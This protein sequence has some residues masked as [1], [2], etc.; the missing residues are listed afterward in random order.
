MH[1]KQWPEFSV[2]F[3]SSLLA[4]GESQQ[5]NIDNAAGALKW[6]CEHSIGIGR[7]YVKPV[8]SAPA[9]CD[10]ARLDVTLAVLKLAAV[11]R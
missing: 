10:R 8:T 6:G 4:I 1:N 9:H 7:N 5:C 3:T 2:L 11:L